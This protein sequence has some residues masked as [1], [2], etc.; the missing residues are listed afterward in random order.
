MKLSVRSIAWLLPLVLS[1]C[2]HKAPQTQMQPPVLAPP[3]QETPPPKTDTSPAS[4]PA[5][6]VNIPPMPPPAVTTTPAPKPAREK[7][8]KS[9]AKNTPQ[10]TTPAQPPQVASNATPEEN[11]AGHLSSEDAPDLHKQTADALDEIEHGLNG[12]TRSLNDQEKKTSAQI[13][14]FLKQARTALAS[15]DVDG[16]RTLAVKAKVLLDELNQ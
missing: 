12:I 3:V 2:A 11:A 9:S 6:I 8:K 1:A 4:L 5:P 10:S 16:A 14:A 15:S 7:K 13:R